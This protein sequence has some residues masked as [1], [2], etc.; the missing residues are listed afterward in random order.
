MWPLESN[1]AKN[2]SFDEIKY[3]FI[4]WIAC[5]VL[6]FNLYNFETVKVYK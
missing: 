5:Y 1:E 2:D 6:A 3:S 4:E